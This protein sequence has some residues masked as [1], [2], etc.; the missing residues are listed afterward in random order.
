MKPSQDRRV[1]RALGTWYPGILG[2]LVPWHPGIPGTWVT[3]HPGILC[4][5]VPGYHRVP[6]GALLFPSLLLQA[7]AHEHFFPHKNILFHLY[8]C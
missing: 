7:S 8:Y 1:L 5:W 2:D 6:G 3:W 4:A